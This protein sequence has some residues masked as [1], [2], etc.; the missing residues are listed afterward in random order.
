M[1]AI[2]VP[3]TSA[4]KTLGE[5]IEAGRTAKL[6]LNSGTYSASYQLT[7][8]WF[9][10]VTGVR[11]SNVPYKGAAQMTMDI[12]S[13]QLDLALTDAGAALP[14]IQSAKMRA[15]AVTGERRHPDLP[16]VPTMVEMG[17]AG[18]VNYTWSSLFVSAAVPDAV[19]ATL[20]EVL[21]KVFALPETEEVVIR[22]GGVDIMPFGPAEMRDFQLAEYERTKRLVKLAGFEPQ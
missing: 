19:V 17:Y 15:L 20:W 21:K 12:V 22:K 1:V 5:L 16:D 14:M 13:N 11:L 4:I 7:G 9:G 6:P 2:V 10:N 18:F 3:G 8:A